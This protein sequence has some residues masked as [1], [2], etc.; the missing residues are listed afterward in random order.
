MKTLLENVLNGII[1]YIFI[2]NIILDVFLFVFCITY[3]IYMLYKKH[4][5]KRGIIYIKR[6]AIW[7]AVIGIIGVV[8]KVN[9][10]LMSYNST[11][12]SG[13]D[14]P[15]NQLLLILMGLSLGALIANNAHNNDKND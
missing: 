8:M 13:S 3:G 9:W 7:G 11:V 14:N 15:A 10:S 1:S 6:G 2:C 5:K 12:D 4:N